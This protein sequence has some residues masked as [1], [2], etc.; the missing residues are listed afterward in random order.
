MHTTAAVLEVILVAGLC[1]VCVFPPLK[2]SALPNH[3]TAVTTAKSFKD[4]AILIP[5]NPALTFLLAKVSASNRNTG[6]IS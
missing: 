6:R 5:R 1:T 2:P 4:L 3:S